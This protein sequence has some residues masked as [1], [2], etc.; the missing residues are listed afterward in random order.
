M[1][2][3]PKIIPGNEWCW[4]KRPVQE[5]EVCLPW[6]FMQEKQGHDQCLPEE[7]HAAHGGA[8]SHRP[9]N[10]Q[11]PRTVSSGPHQHPN[12]LPRVASLLFS[13]RAGCPTF[14]GLVPSLTALTYLPKTDVH[15]NFSPKWVGMAP[16]PSPNGESQGEDMHS[17]LLS[18]PSAPGCLQICFT[19]K[20]NKK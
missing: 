12:F 14:R 15:Q 13:L 1:L 5:W 16:L 10:V 9:P 2:N 11:G 19:R 18:P 6:E 3:I 7:S 8:S 20:T 17:F 4:E